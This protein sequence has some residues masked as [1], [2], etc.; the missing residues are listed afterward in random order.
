MKIKQEIKRY[1]RKVKGK[2]TTVFAPEHLEALARQSEFIQRSSS[3]L[4]G[5]DFVELMTT[6][7]IEDPAISLEGLCAILCTNGSIPTP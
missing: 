3:K 6:E 5:K 1:A 2:L 7:M 4:A